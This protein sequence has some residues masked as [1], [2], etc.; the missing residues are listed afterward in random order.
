MQNQTCKNNR[1]WPNRSWVI[2]EI[3]GPLK[4]LSKEQELLKKNQ[5]ELTVVKQIYFMQVNINAKVGLLWWS[6]G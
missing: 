5:I 6:S 3:K 4:T 1:Y 2:Q